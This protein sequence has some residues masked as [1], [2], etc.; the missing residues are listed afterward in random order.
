ME[1]KKVLNLVKL[2]LNAC[3]QT[4]FTKPNVYKV[5]PP[6][7]ES[8]KCS[9]QQIINLDTDQVCT[10]FKA[11]PYSSSDSRK[12]GT[13]SQAIHLIAF[14]GT[15]HSITD[16]MTN[17]S[18]IKKQIDNPVAP[19]IDL[20]TVNRGWFS[21][22]T[23]RVHSGF[24]NA[25]DSLKPDIL[26][27]FEEEGLKNNL[28]DSKVIITGHSLGSA[29]AM[30]CA[31][32]LYHLQNKY[33]CHFSVIGVGGPRCFDYYGSEMMNKMYP[34]GIR[35]CN[36]Y[37]IVT[38]AVTINSWHCFES[39]TLWGYQSYWECFLNFEWIPRVSLHSMSSYLQRLSK[40]PNYIL[41]K[42]IF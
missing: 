30:C 35:I 37:D 33:N 9:F 6:A 27:Y 10:I 32:D 11:I 3:E 23:P 16:W 13:T 24:W 25:W 7:A 20:K 38:F 29:I 21:K 19:S 17:F 41:D 22:K 26:R 14:R 1:S 5:F 42:F 39:L 31:Y 18:I 36:G 15:D 2:S 4:Y 28:K 12:S 34:H 40:T 8:L